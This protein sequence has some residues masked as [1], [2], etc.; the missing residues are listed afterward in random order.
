MDLF[1]A[2]V[3]SFP[4]IIFTIPLIVLMLFW[5]FAFAGLIDIEIFDFDTDKETDADSGKAGSSSATVFET[6]GLDGV[7]LTVAL[8]LLDLYAFAFI[9][10]LRKYLAPLFDGILSATLIGS[11][12]ALIAVLIAIPLAALSIKPLKR[13]FVTH[14]GLYKDEMIGLICV[15]TTG[16]VNED[17]GQAITEDG[18]SLSVRA[19]T[20][21]DMCK[22]AKVALIE[23]DKVSD[24]YTVVSEAELIAMSSSSVPLNQ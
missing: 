8:T 4:T 14:E 7:P 13:F 5:L 18:Q 3:F 19:T 21:N 1:L 20:P 10:L 9:Y 16:K 12:M 17:F 24:T 15:L 22:G 23:I 11:L 2:D 6:L